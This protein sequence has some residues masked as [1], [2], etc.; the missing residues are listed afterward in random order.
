MALV[1]KM[2]VKCMAKCSKYEKKIQRALNSN[3]NFTDTNK[4]NNFF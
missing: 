3:D 2:Y 1:C 4:F